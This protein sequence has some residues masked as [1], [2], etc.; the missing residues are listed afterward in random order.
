MSVDI[1][2]SHP[3]SR[4][5]PQTPTPGC[6]HQEPTWPHRRGTVQGGRH[7]CWEWTGMIIPRP[8]ALHRLAKKGVL[9]FWGPQPLVHGEQPGSGKA[10]SME[11]GEGPSAHAQ[12]T[13]EADR[14]G[15]HTG[16][17][18]C[19]L[20]RPSPSDPGLITSTVRS[21][22]LDHCCRLWLV[23]SN[24]LCLAFPISLSP[25]LSEAGRG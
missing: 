13:S 5:R 24:L 10:E 1:P 3:A 15:R 14:T 23:P 2:A 7:G 17:R 18:T 16:L 6:P 4:G 12:V 21:L 20:P 9:V 8:W 11:L 19:P 22:M 25:H